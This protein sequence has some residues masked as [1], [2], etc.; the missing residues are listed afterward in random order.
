MY[1]PR[2]HILVDT[3]IISEIMRRSPDTKVFAWFSSLENPAISTITV[4][5]IISGLHRTA[6]Y[7][8][9]AWFRRFSGSAVT[10]L[11]IDAE[12][13]FWV[14]EKRGLFFS[15]GIQVHQA[16]AFIA[17][18]AWRHGLILATRN[19]KDFT[20]FDIPLFNPFN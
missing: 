1:T 3:N 11:P 20:E 19:T 15:K 17:A 4:E 13:A 18:T 2:S 12:M 8:K 9:E 7:E 6:Y 16:D 10:I 5:E 14:G